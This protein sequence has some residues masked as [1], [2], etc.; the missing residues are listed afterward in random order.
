M[1]PATSVTIVVFA[2]I[3]SLA[4][5][6]CSTAPESEPS[7]A[8]EESE[9]EPQSSASGAAAITPDSPWGVT[10]EDLELV[11]GDRFRLV[12][13]PG[14]SASGLWGTWVYT[15]DSSVGSAAVHAGLVSF[16]DGGEVEVGVV[17]GEP[18][19]IGSYLNGVDSGHWPE[20]PISFT[21]LD[22]DERIFT[23]PYRTIS[24]WTDSEDLP[25]GM[26]VTLVLPPDGEV[27]HVWGTGEYTSDSSIG[28][29][30]VHA[31]LITFAEGGE[32]TLRRI[33][34][35]DEY[36]GSTRNG[37]TT[38]SYGTYEGTFIFVEQDGR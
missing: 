2:I 10:V 5:V 17:A 9:P 38:D 25:E 26:D 23:E 34:G 16:E 6:G 21:F 35:L 20:W 30:A 19:Y 3:A 14:G 13:P 12:L 1:K 36:E 8:A 22:D 18:F 31:G 15:H 28:T 24:W 32:V 4:L 11:P 7:A 37:V 33:D 27:Y 29:A